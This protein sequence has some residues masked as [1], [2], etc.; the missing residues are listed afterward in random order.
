MNDLIQ[1]ANTFAAVKHSGQTRKYT[2]EPYVLHPISVARRVSEF[3]DSLPNER[4]PADSK[5]EMVAAALLHDTVEDTDA[6]IEEIEMIF[7]KTVAMYVWYL[8]DSPKYTGNR[9][10]RK[11]M[12]CQR[13]GAAPAEVKVI[14]VFDFMDNAPSIKKNDPRFFQ[15]FLLEKMALFDAM[16]I[17]NLTFHGATLPLDQT[18]YSV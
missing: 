17:E 13:L 15:Q 8:T 11:S 1:K 12:D 7:G 14:K 6:T 18:I 5:A 10:H 3:L 4:F 9:A 16:D 2:N